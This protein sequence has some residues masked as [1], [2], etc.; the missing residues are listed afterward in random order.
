MDFSLQQ[1]INKKPDL[2]PNRILKH[3][4]PVKDFDYKSNI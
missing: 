4:I 1:Y 3:L 2:P